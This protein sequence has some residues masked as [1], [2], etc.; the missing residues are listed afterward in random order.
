MGT[1]CHVEVVHETGGGS[2]ITSQIASDFSQN[3]IE[4]F[5]CLNVVHFNLGLFEGKFDQNE[6]FEEVGES[7]F[8][9]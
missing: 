2:F 4:V 9:S 5:V 7:V 1:I 8:T 3:L 6:L